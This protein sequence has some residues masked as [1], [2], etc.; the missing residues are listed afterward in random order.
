MSVVVLESTILYSWNLKDGCWQSTILYSGNFQN[1]FWQST[2]LYSGNFQNVFWQSTI[3]YSWNLEYECLQ[4]TIFYSCNLKRSFC[5]AQYLEYVDFFSYWQWKEVLTNVVKDEEKK[6]P[7]TSD[8]STELFMHSQG[9]V[10]NYFLIQ[11]FIREGKI[12]NSWPFTTVV[13]DFK[14]E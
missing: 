8:H 3:Q 14:N 9:T 11:E 13:C 10:K 1:V 6:T 4:N 7:K 2:I 12:C 5:Q